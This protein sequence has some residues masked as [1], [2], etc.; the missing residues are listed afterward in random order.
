MGKIDIEKQD[1][2]KLYKIR[3]T[4]D[5]LSEK[6]SIKILKVENDKLLQQNLELKKKL[7]KKEA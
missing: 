2:V 3:K 4:L 6:N 5:E 7:D 1:S